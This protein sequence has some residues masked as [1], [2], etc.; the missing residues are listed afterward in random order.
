MLIMAK[1]QQLFFVKISTSTL[2][3][4]CFL[5]TTMLVYWPVF[6][7]N[8]AMLALEGKACWILANYYYYYNRFTTLYPGLPR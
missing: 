6:Q 1:P 5:T 8:L 7:D 3:L 2:L 4:E